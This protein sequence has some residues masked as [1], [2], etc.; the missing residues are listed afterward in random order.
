MILSEH[1]LTEQAEALIDSLQ[2]EVVLLEQKEQQMEGLRQAVVAS[3]DAALESLMA[4]IARTDVEQ[5][6]LDMDLARRRAA[7]TE[8][9]APGQPVMRLGQLAQALEGPQGRVVDELRGEV[10]QRVR[11]LR[12]RHLETAILLAECS[13]INRL[14]LDTLLGRGSSVETYDASGQRRG[15]MDGG[16]LNT[17]R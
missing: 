5:S 9:L 4:A 1:P 8:A 2:R 13:R 6:R 7:V 12:R 16:L 10:L 17:E 3:D 15:Q 14:L 11:R